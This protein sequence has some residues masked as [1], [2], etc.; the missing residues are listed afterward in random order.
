MKTRL[1]AFALTAALAGPVL[2]QTPA[3]A[4]TYAVTTTTIA[5]LLDKPVLRAIFEK[6][7]PEIVANPQIDQ[8]RTL[9]LPDIVQY[10]PEIIT[11]AK[12]AAI[13]TELKALPPQ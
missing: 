10:V 13:D 4:T 6:H 1:L 2:A 3:P 7:L 11:P 5:D 8:G 12:L 9:T